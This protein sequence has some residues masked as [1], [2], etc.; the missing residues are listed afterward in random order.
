M[1][2]TERPGGD[3]LFGRRRL[4][5]RVAFWFRAGSRHRPWKERAMLTCPRCGNDAEY[6][7]DEVF[8]LFPGSVDELLPPREVQPA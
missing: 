3:G 6:L 8:S 4:A 5:R 2:W 1:G 7:A